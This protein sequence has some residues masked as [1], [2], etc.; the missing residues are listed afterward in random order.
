[1]DLSK[2]FE[3]VCHSKLIN[4]LDEIGIKHKALNLFKSYLDHRT[5]K[6]QIDNVKSSLTLGVPQGTVLSPILFIIYVRGLSN[7]LVDGSLY[8]YTDDTAI[9]VSDN[10]WGDSAIRKTEN[11]LK[12]NSHMVF[13]QQ[14][15]IKQQQNGL[16]NIFEYLKYITKLL[17][18]KSPCPKL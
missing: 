11:S 1:M 10:T 15:N 6:V 12:K 18:Y 9:L 14:P 5:H 16:S 8:S 4:Y 13:K 17:Y 7:L 3:Q 2:A